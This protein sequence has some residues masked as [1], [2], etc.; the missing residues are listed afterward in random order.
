MFRT[1]TLC[2]RATHRPRV[3]PSSALLLAAALVAGGCSRMLARV[4]LQPNQEQL[5][6]DGEPFTPATQSLLR[7]SHWLEQAQTLEV[8][9]DGAL[10]TFTFSGRD[11][12][13]LRVTRLPLET[14]VPRLHYA[15]RT[16]P[17]AFDALNLRLAE[18]SRNGQNVPWAEADDELA[19]FEAPQLDSETPY[20]L[21][22]DYDFAPDAR[23]RPLRVG[24]V[25]NCLEPG[26]WESYAVDRA[27]ELYHAWFRLPL[28]VYLDLVREVNGLAPAFVESALRW[29]DERAPLDL[30]RLR[31]VRQAPRE[32]PAALLGDD[33][34]VGYSTQDSRQKLGQ[35]FVTVG[36]PGAERAPLERAD[37]TRA[38]LGLVR[39]VA[40]GIYARDERQRFDVSFLREL[41][42]A[43]VSRVAPL[44]HYA[45][46]RSGRPRAHDGSTHLELRLRL[47][48][49]RSL[50]LGNLPLA[51]LVPQE[52]FVIHGFGV[53]VLPAD[54]PAE[55]TRLLLDEGPAPSFAYVVEERDG[56]EW[57][58]NS[59]ALGVEQVF[60]RARPEARDPH[61]EL[62]L[63]S[64]ERIVD[65]VR[66]RVLLPPDLA[67]EARAA[68]A[69]Y[70]SPAYFSYRDDN[71]R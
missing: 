59:H 58:L 63:S 51:L 46:R 26:L 1:F 5:R 57:A 42:G 29:S 23:L 22:A 18:Y 31:Q 8:R 28:P 40:P 3:G 11:G 68:A 47:G 20:T 69:A 67:D 45:W 10:G 71:L 49:G 60:V 19:H 43:V 34:P 44:T 35:G 70:V 53:G 50:V 16:P 38:P 25:N 48:A 62:T 55:R 13:E 17:D 61:L 56:R 24:L 6:D 15:P 37:L 7:G 41:R 2:A 27:G 30:G 32:V 65:L 9:R 64:Y 36:A 54:S 14:L 21:R 12:R 52:D 4:P 39:F 66:Y 33:E